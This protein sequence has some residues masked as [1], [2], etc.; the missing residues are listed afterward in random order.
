MRLSLALGAAITFLFPRP[1]PAPPGVPALIRQFERTYNSAKSLR[2]NFLE[3]Y[4]DNGKKVRSEAGIAYFSK[5]GKMR[6]EYASPEPNLYVVD[7]KWSWFYVPADHTVTRIRAKQSSDARTPLALLAGEM[8][9]SRLCKRVDAES[10]SGPADPRG[11]VLRCILRG[12]EEIAPTGPAAQAIAPSFR[13][14][15]ALFELNPENGQLLRILV[16]DSGGTQVEF[17][18]SNWV[19]DPPLDEAR[20]H[21][22]APKGVAIIDGN[23]GDGPISTVQRRAEQP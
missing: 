6:W 1:S 7:G 20:F 4:F 18:F 8:K 12:D 23:L 16:V 3:T 10:A 9:V 5:P 21:F 22:L 11:V 14:P 17:R 2:T 13:S 15:Y 19:F